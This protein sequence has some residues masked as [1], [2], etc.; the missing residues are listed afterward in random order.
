MKILNQHLF[1]PGPL[2]RSFSRDPFPSMSRNAQGQRPWNTSALGVPSRAHSRRGGPGQRTGYPQGRLW[3]A[4]PAHQP[5]VQ[6]WNGFHSYTTQ[7]T[8]TAYSEGNGW[9]SLHIKNHH[10][11]LSPFKKPSKKG[12]VKGKPNQEKLALWVALGLRPQGL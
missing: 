4:A 7:S 11:Y 8:Y 12:R 5:P 2:H 6:I 10:C 3:L 9:D 1:P